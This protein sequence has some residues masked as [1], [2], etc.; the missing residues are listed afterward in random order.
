M[1]RLGR[2]ALL[3]AALLLAP[4]GTAS[5]ECAWVLWKET[6]TIGN[7]GRLD[8]DSVYASLSACDLA[9][10]RLVYS[11]WADGYKAPPGGLEGNRTLLA[12]KDAG[13]QS[14]RCLPDT[15]DPRGVKAR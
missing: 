5:A 8:I 3:G 7:D 1:R 2:R 14:Y 15:V 9:I 13:S 10:G 12:Q 11:L 6:Y 4:V